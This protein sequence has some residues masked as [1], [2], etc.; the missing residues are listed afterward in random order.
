MRYLWLDGLRGLA[1]GYVLIFHLLGDSNNLSQF[2]WVSVDL[3][4]ILSGFVLSEKIQFA[5]SRGNIGI[6]IFIKARI[7]RLAPMLYI[8]LFFIAFERLIRMVLKLELDYP[9]TNLY[10]SSNFLLSLFI[11]IFLAQFLYPPSILILIPLWSLSVEFYS[12]LINLLFNLSSSVIRIISQGFL[13]FILILISGYSANP[14]INWMNPRVWLFCFGRAFLGFALGQIV[15]NSRNLDS[16]IFLF[17]WSGC[18]ILSALGLVASWSLE[19]DLFILFCDLFM[20]SFVAL[21]IKVKNPQEISILGWTLSFLGTTS[22]GVYL[23]HPQIIG[24]FNW[25]LQKHL[26]FVLAKIY[27]VLIIHGSSLLASHLITR[28]LEPRVRDRIKRNLLR[29]Y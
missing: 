21:L 28:Y 17:R 11:S 10:S 29:N 23:F 2:G 19:R 16:K 4:F 22:Y 27:L 9:E 5:I 14:E 12:N 6:A 25:I 24:A 7:V 8:S 26:N 1:A 18:T 15:F 3:F 13:G 20:S